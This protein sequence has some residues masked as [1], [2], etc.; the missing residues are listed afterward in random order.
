[1]ASGNRV[2]ETSVVNAI[3]K[4]IKNI[5]GS[6]VRKRRGGISNRGEPDLY[7]SIW[8]IHFEIEVKAPDGTPTKVQMVRLSEWGAAGV[9]VRGIAY[10]LEDAKLIIR[11]GLS[12]F[13]SKLPLIKANI[14]RFIEG[15]HL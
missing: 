4:Y 7:G 3:K 12:E 14:E 2:S 9:T 8:G 1:M 11:H 15:K 5:P 10:S 6:K 13:L